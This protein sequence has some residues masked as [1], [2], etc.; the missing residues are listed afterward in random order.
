[1]WDT[2][3][4]GYSGNC[5]SPLYTGKSFGRMVG[6]SVPH[7]LRGKRQNQNRVPGSQGHLLERFQ[8]ISVRA[9]ASS[10]CSTQKVL[11][12][13]QTH[14]LPSHGGLYPHTKSSDILQSH[15]FQM[16]HSTLRSALKPLP[17]HPALNSVTCVPTHMA[18]F[19]AHRK[20]CIWFVLTC[21]QKGRER[22]VTHPPCAIV[23]VTQ[24]PA[25]GHAV[26]WQGTV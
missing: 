24:V 25:G 20:P 8:G 9:L 16:P 6:A 11:K 12:R 26:I 15:S 19:F 18:F 2:V 22:G 5:P 13:L 17:A 3:S 1:M 23:T 21:P 4:T 7:Y 10:L 14:L